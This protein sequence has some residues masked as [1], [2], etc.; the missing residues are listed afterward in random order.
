M[1][2]EVICVSPAPCRLLVLAVK[3]GLSVDC[4]VLCEG[5]AAEHKAVVFRENRGGFLAKI[6]KIGKNTKK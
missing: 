5:M 3:I 1:Q 2:I 4:G 6:S